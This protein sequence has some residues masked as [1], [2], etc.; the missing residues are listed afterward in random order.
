MPQFLP[1][2]EPW[3]LLDDEPVGTQSAGPLTAGLG[4][5]FVAEAGSSLRQA[6]KSE[7]LPA[8]G[9]LF[10]IKG[11][12]TA[13]QAYDLP[14]SDRCAEETLTVYSTRGRMAVFLD[15]QVPRAIHR[16]DAEAEEEASRPTLLETFVDSLVGVMLE[17]RADAEFLAGRNPGHG[18]ESPL[19]PPEPDAFESAAR[20][21]LARLPWP[22]AAE[23]LLSGSREPRMDVIVRIALEFRDDLVRLAKSP[24]RILRRERSR[25]PVG[26][27][28][29][30]D[31]ACLVWLVRQ[32]GR[33]AV[34][35]AGPAQQILSVVRTEDY[36]TL[37]N[38]VLKDF[39]RRCIAASHLYIREHKA[40][41]EQSTRYKAVAVL[42]DVCRGLLRE[43]L[44]TQVRSLPS[45]PLPNYVLLHDR[46]YRELWA[47]YV[48]LVRR[49]KDNDKAWRWQRRLWADFVRLR[50]ACELIRANAGSGD[51]SRRLPFVHDL[52]LREEQDDGCWLHP[53]DWPGPIWLRTDG[54]PEVI[55]QII[56]PHAVDKDETY[57]GIPV[58][59][60]LGLTGADMA[61]VFHPID[62]AAG[63]RRACLFVW[64][65]HSAAEEADSPQVLAQSQRAA[66]ALAR[67]RGQA[68]SQGVAFRGL[69]LRS[70]LSGGVLDLPAHSI[71]RDIEVAGAYVPSDP[72]AWHGPEGVF[73]LRYVLYDCVTHVTDGA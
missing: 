42:R 22:V 63:G 39:V 23:R 62:A 64:A 73:G 28:Q 10:L 37:E 5:V 7:C 8:H 46:A 17:L 31:S 20:L 26:R 68:S 44:L 50:V 67:L 33:T 9:P 41:F 70:H 27:V 52:W 48:R 16:T 66:A 59:A 25:T 24:R 47:W 19:P 49:Q 13:V 18:A 11:A 60:W 30:M 32:P 54:R 38:R 21:P 43:S 2:P 56:H 51:F 58:A 61:V 57:D 6:G 65:I 45:M 1:L 14:A 35:K 12:P 4:P 40:R 3:S 29:Q 71:A 53:M 72:R 69:I 55:A 36:D 34:E 15:G